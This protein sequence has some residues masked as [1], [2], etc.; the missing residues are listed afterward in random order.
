MEYECGF[1]CA[2]GRMGCEARNM[3]LV[4]GRGCAAKGSRGEVCE[5]KG[6]VNEPLAWRME[7]VVA[8]EVLNGVFYGVGAGLAPQDTSLRFADV[9]RPPLLP[10]MLPLGRTF[11]L[12]TAVAGR[13]SPMG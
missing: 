3:R 13:P 9:M 4:T 7:M 2:S 6:H 10:P 8:V 12:N 1:Y 11:S 5:L